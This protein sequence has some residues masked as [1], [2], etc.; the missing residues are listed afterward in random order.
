MAENKKNSDGGKGD[1]SRGDGGKGGATR[2]DGGG[3]G[4]GGK[5]DAP[6]KK[7]LTL[8]LSFSTVTTFCVVL[9]GAVCMAFVMGVIVGRGDN[10]ETHLPK[11]VTS[12][13]AKK[14]TPIPEVEDRITK[15]QVMPK[16]ELDYSN[17]LKDRGDQ[18]AVQD[19]TT[20]AM[21]L[22]VPSATPPLAQNQPVAEPVFQD[23]PAPPPAIF[24]YI[25]QVATFTDAESVDRLREKLEGS[26]LRTK[27]EKAGKFYKVLVL[28]RGSSEQALDLM[29]LMVE[30]K[31]GE[32][33][34]RSKKAVAP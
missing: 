20:P 29:A 18:E 17:S 32:P 16:E 34:Q 7:S 19:T 33:V 8:T 1:G 3:K 6:A 31:L 5:G 26:G 28:M 24:D 4:D 2:K 13:S 14:S 23:V 12:E 10:P 11:F 9:L 22:T 21:V 15:P 27:M 30:M 25:F